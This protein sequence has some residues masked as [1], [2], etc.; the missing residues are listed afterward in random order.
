MSE[1]FLFL[2][3][4]TPVI[5]VDISGSVKKTKDFFY[6]CGG[7]INVLCSNQPHM[8]VTGDKAG[9]KLMAGTSI[10]AAYICGHIAKG[11]WNYRSKN[12]NLMNTN[13]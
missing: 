13:I 10:S 3:R 11:M 8:V 12:Q 2:Q 7:A 1:D 5:G 6:L 9:K 4:S